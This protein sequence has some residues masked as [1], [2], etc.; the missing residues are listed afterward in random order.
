MNEFIIFSEK[1]EQM[2]KNKGGSLYERFFANLF[3]E[4][5][6]DESFEKFQCRFSTQ[7]VKKRESIIKNNYFK[8]HRISQ[9][10][11]Q[12]FWHHS[13]TFPI[14]RRREIT[15]LFRQSHKASKEKYQ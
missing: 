10:H 5:L 1:S 6:N 2:H 14:P 7:Y 9:T 13:R 8:M 12:H 4:T 11:Q 3:A 15:N